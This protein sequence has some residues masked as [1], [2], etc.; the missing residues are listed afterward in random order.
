MRGESVRAWSGRG[1]APLAPIMVPCR[2][3]RQYPDAGALGSDPAE[4]F[5]VLG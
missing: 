4:R 5:V 2:P 3:Q 1:A